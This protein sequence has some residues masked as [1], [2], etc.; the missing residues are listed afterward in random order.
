MA[1][2]SEGLKLQEAWASDADA[3][4][5]S[6]ESEGLDREVGWPESYQTAGGDLPPV[7]IFNQVWLEVT[8]L[9]IDI[10]Q[11]GILEWNANQTYA[12]PAHVVSTVDNNIYR[13]VQAGGQ[14]QEPSAD[15][16]NDYWIQ[17]LPVPIATATVA[18]LVRRATS[19]EITAGTSNVGFV[20]PAQLAARIASIPAARSW[21][22]LFVVENHGSRSVLRIRDWSGGQGTKP[23]TG[24]VGSTG[25]VSNHANATD[26]RG[27]TG[28]QGLQGL[29]GDSGPVGPQGD[30]GPKGETGPQGERGIQ[31]QRGEKGDTGPRGTTGPRGFTGPTGSGVGPQGDR[32]EKGDTGPRGFNGPQGLRGQTGSAGVRG[33]RGEQGDPGPQGERGI[34]GPAGSRGPTGLKGDTGPQGDPGADA[35]NL[36][37]TLVVRTNI[38]TTASVQGGSGN[39]TY[40]WFVDNM[41]PSG[42]N[43][44]GT[45]FTQTSAFQGRPNAISHSTNWQEIIVLVEDTTNNIKAYANHIQ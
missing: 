34:Q 45:Q 5:A 19:S 7:E 27:A 1:R 28:I 26:I 43:V 14:A 10:A 23:A 20:T 3:L 40:R 36:T 42:N 29:Q 8:S 13:S 6:P 32:G 44:P 11:H 37:V 15:S 17:L 21:V 38:S 22:P 24:Y 31:G 33:E 16:D 9:L 41:G 12:H 18:G 4:K 30:L 2:N 25:L 35:N 39:Y